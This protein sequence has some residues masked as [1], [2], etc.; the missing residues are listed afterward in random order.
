MTTCSKIPFVIHYN[1]IDEPVIIDKS[2]IKIIGH[3][4]GAWVKV[5]DFDIK[6]PDMI[7]IS[8]SNKD[9]DGVLCADAILVLKKEKN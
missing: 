8:L 3:T 5:G 6:E 2:Q 9:I 1:N 4:T 7:T